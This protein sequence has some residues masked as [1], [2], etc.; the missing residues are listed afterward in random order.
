MK[1]LFISQQILLGIGKELYL[2]L[3]H[4]KYLFITLT[5]TGCSS[6]LPKTLSMEQPGNFHENKPA[7]KEDDEIIQLCYFPYKDLSN[8]LKG[9]AQR[10]LS[11]L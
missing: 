2:N 10:Y 11:I 8:I 1:N 6:Y 4:V 5:L 7:V 3:P 9:K